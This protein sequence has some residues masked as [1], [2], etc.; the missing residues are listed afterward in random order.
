METDV[1]QLVQTLHNT[2]GRVVLVITG[3]GTQALAWLLGVA[4]ASRTLLEALIPY[5]WQA[6]DDFLGQRPNQ[7]VDAE[8]ARLMAGRALT[9]ARLLCQDGEAVIGLA[10]TATV[11]TDRPKRGEHRAHIATWQ[12]ERV[13]SYTLHLEKGQRDREGEEGLVS[14][15]ILNALAQ[16]YGLA[17]PL[18]LAL[19]A[20][21]N[22][23]VTQFDLSEA[24][25]QLYRRQIDY[26][27][28]YADGRTC[29]REAQ[30][31]VLLSGA[32]NPLHDGHLG[33][34]NAAET[35]LTR[36]VA[37]E[38]AATNVDKPALPPQAVL[39][40][41]AQFAGR[42]PVFVS[43]APTFVEKARL[44]PGA[45][46]V[47]GYDTAE[48]ILHNRYYGHSDSEMLAALS[49]IRAQGCRF[50]VAG[51]VQDHERFN[52]TRDLDIP[53]GFADL[54]QPL[55]GF[56]H[57]ISSTALRTAGKRGSR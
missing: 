12:S 25:H 11:V 14:R 33:M 34:A 1:H 38:L 4:G 57:D 8:T 39:E 29:G 35:Y 7:Y 6:F 54:F 30:P 45:T 55:P 46:F 31:Q 37:F 47:T 40:R 9:R 56:R 19:G 10:C 24:A 21:D 15:L 2:P 23:T 53:A 36:P 27:G 32:F 50:L 28:V 43:N 41:V 44:Y 3:A 16:A 22:L 48:R 51:R 26:F 13:V 18:D 52:T 42:W 20:G 49:T 17:G 5:D